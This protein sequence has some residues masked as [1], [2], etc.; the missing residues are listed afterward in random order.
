MKD[1]AFV[2]AEA[3]HPWTFI[4]RELD[5]RGWTLRDLAMRM[6]APKP[7]DFAVNF[8]TLELIEACSDPTFKHYAECRIGKATN[9]RIAA[10]FGQQAQEWDDIKELWRRSV[11]KFGIPNQTEA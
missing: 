11:E 4:E 2:P 7:K 6:D 8:M 5:A 3:V 10:A 1:E 9:A